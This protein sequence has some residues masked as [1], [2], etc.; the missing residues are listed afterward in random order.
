VSDERALLLTD[1]VDSTRLTELLG[2]AP[3]AALWT[4]HDHAA[5]ERLG[6][7]RGR[8]IDKSDGFLLLFDRAA[9]A[10]GYALDYHHALAAID[11]RLRARA[12]LHVGQV[13]LRANHAA[14]VAR[15]AKPFEVDGVAKP[16]AAR[17]MALAAGGQTLLTAAARAAL[18]DAAVTVRLEPVGH[19]Q[20]KGIDEPV[21]LYAAAIDGDASALATPADGDKGWRVVLETGRWRPVRETPNNLPSQLTSFIGREQEIARLRGLLATN[22][23]LTLTGAGGAGK[24]RLAIEV[25]GEALGA[26]AHG[27]WLVELAALSEAQLV[28]QAVMQALGLREQ[29]GRSLMEVIGGYLASRK[30]LLVID[31]A[32]HV[33]D[34]CVRLIDEILRHSPDVA[35]LVTSR[36][37]LGIAGE[38]TYRVPSLTVPYRSGE[39]SPQAALTYEGVRLFVDRARLLRPEFGLT[40]ENARAVASICARLDGIPLA[41]ELAAPRLRSMSVEELNQRLDQRFALLTDGSRAALPRHRTLRSMID[42]SYD[43]LT[44]TEQELLRR[45]SMFAGGWTLGSAEAVCAGNGIDSSAIVEIMTSLVD[46]SLVLSDEVDGATRYRMLETL[47]QY[48]SDRL[49]E[50]GEEAQWRD[51]HFESCQSLADAAFPHLQGADQRAWLARLATEHDNLRAALSWSVASRPEDGLRLA[52]P[53]AQFWRVNGHLAAEGREWFSQL[54]SAAS[55]GGATRDRARAL[56]SAAI[57]AEHQGDYAA[58]KQMYQQ[59]LDMCRQIGEAKGAAYAVCGLSIVALDQGDY[60]EAEMRCREGVATAQALDDQLL[61]YAYLMNLGL[62][63]QARGDWAAARESFEAAIALARSIGNPWLIGESMKELGRSEC[64]AGTYD[65]AREHLT[66]SMSTSCELRDRRRVAEVLEGFAGLA[67]AAD[68]ASRAVRCLGFAEA[69]RDEIGSVRSLRDQRRY[70]RDVDAA[71]ARMPPGAFGHAWDEGRAMTLEEAVRYA[72]DRD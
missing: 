7:W 13:T 48:A 35:V 70:D 23:L 26:Y 4:A 21:A 41:I 39:V 30:L 14:D 8:E 56:H 62:A 58:A 64:D 40:P 20:L 42:W 27:V 24:T 31:N 16:I 66:E 51:R 47:R 28:P 52:A 45:V 1:L 55:S 71:R 44:Q 61:L 65:L 59:S 9:D 29:P 2:D 33:L 54:L 68:A 25:A 5:R 67:L 60:A 69:L 12:G 18:G 22:R 37:R 15:G 32:E 36:E 57:L 72:L 3:A 17:V 11:P 53:L 49:R 46:K 34:G 63:V 10:L 6:T 50:G 19:W 38:L 43:L